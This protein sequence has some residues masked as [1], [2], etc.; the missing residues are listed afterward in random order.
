MKKITKY[1]S[2]KIIFALKNRESY[3][4]KYLKNIKKDSM[5]YDL[6]IL[7]ENKKKIK[8]AKQKNIFQIQIKGKVK[9]MNSIF[10]NIYRF[11]NFIKNYKYVCFVEDDNFIFN[12]GLKA[13]ESF[14]NQNPTYVGC[15]GKSFLFEKSK[16]KAHLL[17]SYISPRF[18]H[19]SVIE[20]LK[21]YNQL[22]G[23]VYYSLIRVNIFLKICKKINQINDDNLSEIYFNYLLIIFG[24]LKNLNILYLARIYPRPKIYNIP[25]LDI[26]LKN[27]SLNKEIFFI[28]N[29]I[30]KELKQKLNKFN[31]ENF[32]KES[33]FKYLS[34]RTNP[35]NK[36]I[37]FLSKVK[38][39]I[40]YYF[41]LCNFSCINFIK[42]Q[43]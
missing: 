1:D 29:D 42:N 28:S 40:D 41:L 4:K 33:V 5:N 12:K 35:Q 27:N 23:L 39:K 21:K 37:N 14:L 17:N 43:S 10:C 7:I 6:L 18:D 20:R 11:K 19:A 3:V 8:I 25:K 15:N 31:R 34:I 13:C 24:K 32:L 36:K 9:G 2:L 38:L 16:N 26:W 30:R 22:M